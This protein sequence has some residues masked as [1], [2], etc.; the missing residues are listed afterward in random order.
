MSITYKPQT[1]RE[2]KE[3]ML[4]M[5]DHWQVPFMDFVDDFRRNKD[6]SLLTT[7]FV[8]DHERWDALLASTVEYLCQ[9]QG[10]ET[11]EWVSE[12]PACQDPWFVSGM[13]SLRAISL[14]ESPAPFRAR[15]IFVLGNFL[16]R[17]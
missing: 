8:M 14:V 2:T 7:P 11:P 10:L 6:M 5:P 1:I 16:D 3:R 4:A 9:E 12:V 13:D 17:V 15:K